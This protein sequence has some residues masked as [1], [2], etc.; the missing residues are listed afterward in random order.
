MP[1]DCIHFPVT[2]HYQGHDELDVFA[3]SEA[4]TALLCNCGHLLP[5]EDR[6]IDS[7]GRVFVLN[8]Q[9]QLEANGSTVSLPQFNLLLQKH[10]F[11]LASSCAAKAATDS[12]ASGMLALLAV[13]ER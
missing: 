11:S 12:I 1:R 6:F 7:S 4:L 3:D 8:G 13:A 10:F 2:L 5:F 9:G